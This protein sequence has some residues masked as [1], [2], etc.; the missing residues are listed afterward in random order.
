MK[1]PFV[2]TR[3]FRA[4]RPAG[5]LA[6]AALAFG[7]AFL[8]RFHLPVPFTSGRLPLDRLSL[9]APGLAAALAAQL[10]ALY[11]FGAYDPPGAR[12]RPAA[13]RTLA[14]AALAG[15]ALA[16]YFFLANRRFPRSVVVL[17]VAFD[18]AAV[19]LWRLLLE[20]GRRGRPRR[21]AIVGCGEPAREVAAAI[22]GHP[23]G[24][25]VAGFVVPPGE[26]PGPGA[27]AAGAPPDAEVL[28]P[29][30][31]RP[32]DLPALLASGAVDDVILAAAD[33]SW[34]TRLIDGLA[35][36]RPDH[37]NVLLLPGPFESLIGRMRYRSIHDLPLIEV[38]R[39]TEWRINRPLKR[40]LDLTVGSLLLLLAL[41]ALA[42]SAIA[43]KL[44]SPG[45]VLYRQE[46]VG[47]DRRP[48]TLW[49]L[50]TMQEGPRAPEGRCWPGPTTPG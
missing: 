13:G 23:Y 29:R 3:L 37:T 7:L 42:I 12:G 22:A 6:A 15:L 30:L 49:K 21:V 48:F 17:Y 9:A 35:G 1:R 5:D 47:R 16:G 50:R 36:G 44:T 39:E 4:L 25:V 20:R 8:V 10:V 14:A 45:P 43:V 18:Y 24:L 26:E 40:L 38:V 32:G 11:L 34:Q 2:E 33:D 19:A 31:G 41:P 28:G 27:P 46:R